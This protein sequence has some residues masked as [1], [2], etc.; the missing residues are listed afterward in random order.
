MQINLGNSDDMQ[1]LDSTASIEGILL[2]ESGVDHIHDA[3]D[4]HRRFCDVRGENHLN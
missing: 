2:G 1:M 4:R 3:V